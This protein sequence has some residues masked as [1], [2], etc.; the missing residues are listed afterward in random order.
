MVAQLQTI[1]LV[2]PGSRGLNFSESGNLLS[3]LFATKALNAV[4]DSNGRIGT[5]KGFTADTTTPITA[6]PAIKTM[7]EYIKQDGTKEVI[8]AWDGGIANS[9][10]DPE[11][12]DVSASI[13]DADGRWSM[14]NFNN[15]CIGLQAGQKPAVYTGTT[16]VTVVESTGTAP[17]GGIGL[18]AFGR[19]WVLDGDGKTIQYSGLLDETDWNTVGDSG[20][21][22]MSSVWTGGTDEVTAIAAFNGALVV[23]G[24][25]HI[26]FWVDGAGSAIGMDPDNIYV[27]DVIEGTGCISDLSVQTIGETDL[28]YLSPNGVQSLSRLIAERSNPISTLTKNV[29]K[30]F[31]DSLAIETEADIRS[32]Y[33]PVEGIYILSFPNQNQ[34]WVLDQSRQWRDEEGDLLSVVTE[35]DLAPTSWLSKVDNTLHIGDTHG[36]G[37]YSGFSDNGNS[38]RFIFQSPWMNLGEE[39]ANRLKMLKRMSAILFIRTATD[40][41]FKWAVD[42]QDSGRSIS[43]AAAALA[44]DEWNIGEWNVAEWSGADPLRIISVPARDKGQYY[45]IGI[46]ANVTGAFAVQ[47]VE[48]MT[49]IGRIA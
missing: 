19:L 25:R 37:T 42:F 44:N 38:Y 24:R 43:R 1:D 16:F 33:N 35:W 45:R 47:Q 26:V 41:V 3:P 40:V 7:H 17:D 49:K 11:G 27:A 12:N 30:V 14:Q 21:I 9:I 39:L 31:L 10:T 18:A 20:S 4:I 13:V 36:V 29:R 23:F 32:A 6:T 2:A 22:D 5:R 15:K 46:E 34:S 8:V 48:L 28:L